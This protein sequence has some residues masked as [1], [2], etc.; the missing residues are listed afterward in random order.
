MRER[1]LALLFMIGLTTMVLAGCSLPS[2]YPDLDREAGPDDVSEGFAERYPDDLENIDLDSV[3][4][5]ASDGDI[6]LY[7]MRQRLGGICLEV[8]GNERQYGLS[9]SGGEG[10]LTVQSRTGTYQ[11]RPAPMPEEDGWLVLSENVRVRVTASDGAAPAD[12]GLPP[13]QSTPRAVSDSG[14]RAGASGSVTG[15][16]TAEMTYVVAEGDTA[17]DIAAR[18]AVGLEQLID[19][20]GERLGDHPTLNVGDSIQFGA[21]LTGDDYDCFFGLEGPTAKGETCYE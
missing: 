10:G 9:C 1:R 17:S 20:Q 2:A 19:E 3:R 7:L 13:W 6:D 15:A 12:A 16:G 8:K 14:E 11:V 4:W 18:F 5:V 21:P